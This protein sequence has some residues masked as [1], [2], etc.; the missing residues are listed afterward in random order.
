[1]S[2]IKPNLIEGY[3]LQKIIGKGGMG[4]VLK[5]L[6]HSLDKTVAVKLLSP[7]FSS[8]SEYVK[9]FVREAKIA[10][11]LNHS[12]IMQVLD[13]GHV[14]KHYYIVME[15]I[16]GVSVAQLLKERGRIEEREALRIA[17]KVTEALA[18]AQK[19]GLVHRDIK[20]ENIMITESNEVKLCDMGL[21]KSTRS[22]AGLTQ[23]G[24]FVGTPYYIAPEQAKGGS[25][26]IRCDIYAL[27]MTLY[28]MLS[29]CR[30]FAGDT[31]KVLA[32]QIDLDKKPRDLRT[33][34]PSISPVTATVVKTAIA[35]RRSYRYQEP[36]EF[37]DALEDALDSLDSKRPAGRAVGS[38]VGRVSSKPRRGA[39]RDAGAESRVGRTSAKSPLPYIAV[40]GGMV[41]ILIVVVVLALSGGS[42]PTDT[43]GDEE[44]AAASRHDEEEPERRP[45]Y[46][47][48]TSTRRDSGR[49]DS[50]RTADSRD[51][52]PSSSRSLKR[53]Q[54]RQGLEQMKS[55]IDSLLAQEKFKQAGQLLGMVD[56]TDKSSYYMNG[57]VEQ[58]KR[59]DK[60]WE[61]KDNSEIE[62]IENLITGKELERASRLAEELESNCG[63]TTRR[64]VGTLRKTIARAIADRKQKEEEKRKAAALDTR[65]YAA[66]L[67]EAAPEIMNGKYKDARLKVESKLA[68]AAKA[69]FKKQIDFSQE[70]LKALKKKSADYTGEKLPVTLV[71]G[72]PV[73]GTFIG[74]KGGCW[75]FDAEGGAIMCP[76]ALCDPAKTLAMLTSA[77]NFARGCF[78]LQNLWFTHARREFESAKKAGEEYADFFIRLIEKHAAEL[79]EAYLTE[80]ARPAEELY[81]KKKLLNAFRFQNALELVLDQPGCEKALEKSR[82]LTKRILASVVKETGAAASKNRDNDRIAE[83]YAAEISLFAYTALAAGKRDI[84]LLAIRKALNID[85]DN[86]Y[87]LA[88]M[89]RLK[90]K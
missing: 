11:K 14:D 80:I 16:E 26:D 20:P 28:H 47:A 46:S 87:A 18:A 42:E 83:S 68:E 38:K 34:E 77:S 15:Y 75:A 33:V 53:E 4:V 61:E 72:E 3:T 84:A 70:Q 88:I 50:G 1:M 25:V 55:K 56:M 51:S 79:A 76:L 2:G 9:R 86:P 44:V 24:S 85:A 10:A 43:G 81:G 41:V 35:K 40:I 29:G 31:I 5:A 74:M 66:A 54:E 49:R 21:A 90:K 32:N 27:G 48:G 19:Q 59:I 13:T 82:K 52:A 64:R 58:K 17:I 22:D 45:D 7:K 36:E 67:C 8:D 30:P 6:Q 60:A 62:K 89:D 23:E 73:G 37:G 69:I 63:S 65:K 71:S 39:R 12:N 78:C 57:I